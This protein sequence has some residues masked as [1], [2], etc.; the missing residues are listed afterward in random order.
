MRFA[1]NYPNLVGDDTATQTGNNNEATIDQGTTGNNPLPMV[2]TF[3]LMN[4]LFSAKPR[5]LT[6]VTKL[7][8]LKW[9]LQYGIY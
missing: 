5:I 6:V 1:L 2:G 4:A 8:R 9:R 7:H 3:P